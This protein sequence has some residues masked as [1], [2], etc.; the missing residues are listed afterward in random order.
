MNCACDS[1]KWK[2]PQVNLV[3]TYSLRAPQRSSQKTESETKLIAESRTS[4][5]AFPRDTHRIWEFQRAIAELVNTRL[6][7]LQTPRPKDR[8]AENQ[9][10]FKMRPQ[11]QRTLW[12]SASSPASSL[13]PEIMQ[14]AEVTR[15]RYNRYLCRNS[16]AKPHKYM[17]FSKRERKTFPFIRCWKTV[18][19]FTL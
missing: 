1:A 18:A 19:R 2:A 12:S 8:R 5:Q 16:L 6:L 14:I 7:S 11:T 17:G 15:P 9:A 10:Q 3:W 13:K 4:F